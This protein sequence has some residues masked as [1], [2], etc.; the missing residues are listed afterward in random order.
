MKVNLKGALVAVAA[1][2]SFSA[3][4]F[5]LPYVNQITSFD[6]KNGMP[7]TQ[8]PQNFLYQVDEEKGAQVLNPTLI[9]PPARGLVGR[10]R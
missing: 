10:F 1:L 9:Q 8:Q 3:F 5:D 2:C 7:E 6:S 4:A